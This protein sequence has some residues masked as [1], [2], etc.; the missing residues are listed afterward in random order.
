[1]SRHSVARPVSILLV[2]GIHAVCLPP[3]TF[4]SKPILF[5]CNT[6]A[7]NHVH[8]LFSTRHNTAGRPMTSHA[9]HVSHAVCVDQVLEHPTPHIGYPL[10]SVLGAPAR[11]GGDADLC[12][13]QQGANWC[14]TQYP[15]STLPTRITRNA[16]VKRGHHHVSSRH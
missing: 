5:I 2:P 14:A 10:Y 7:F 13:E 3:H 15:F 12:A 11:M 6:N 16:A 4:L 1:M 9:P 8:R